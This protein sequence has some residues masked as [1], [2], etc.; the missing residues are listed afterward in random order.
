MFRLLMCHS[1]VIVNKLPFNV[2]YNAS[3]IIKWTRLVKESV[4]EKKVKK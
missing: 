4:T 2:Y 1:Y 3:N